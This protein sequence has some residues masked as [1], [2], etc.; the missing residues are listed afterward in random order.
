LPQLDGF[1]H[2]QLEVRFP[3][4][5]VGMDQDEEWCEVVED[6][7]SRRI[8]FHDYAE[9]YSVPGL[10]ERLFHEGLGCRS[11]EVVCGLLSEELEREPGHEPLRVFELGA[12]N[13]MVAEEL[14]SRGTEAIVGVDIIEEAAAAAE[15]DRPGVYEGYEVLDLTA[16]SE[17]Q[18]AE[19]RRRR[20]NC[21]VTVAALG[22]GDIPPRAFAEAYNLVSNGGW[23]AFN[24]KEDF[25]AAGE[26]SGFGH[27]IRRM[28][29]DGTLERRAQRRYPHR[30]SVA[31]EPIHYVA[32]VARKR[33][34]VAA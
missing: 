16:I 31:G 5:D 32:I 19:L 25:L 15:R 21:L 23:V 24:I 8:R 9:I 26:G 12:G 2:H 17:S 22:F 1:I 10:Y 29:V 34:D 20:F 3:K 13:G 33:A 7:E 18:R 14:A 28:L 4:P 27:L 30:L 6:G 11:P